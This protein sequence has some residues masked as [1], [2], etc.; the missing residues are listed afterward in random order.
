MQHLEGVARAVADRQHDV[1]GGD[2]LAAGQH[3]AAHLRRILDVEVHDL[4]LKA[5]LAAQRVDRRAHVL[6][7]RDQAESAD[8]RLADVEDFLRRAGFDE[9]GRAPCGPDGAGP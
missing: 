6:D 9:L 2:V 8:M 3:H 1:I 5:D 7:H 4:A